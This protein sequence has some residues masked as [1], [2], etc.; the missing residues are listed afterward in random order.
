MKF[1]VD[2]THFIELSRSLLAAKNAQTE[3][4]IMISVLLRECDNLT[5][6]WDR[7]NSALT[8]LVTGGPDAVTDDQQA[9]LD[10]CMC[11]EEDKEEI[12]L[13]MQK[14]AKLVAGGK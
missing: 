12:K 10:A 11:V 13:T 7:S 3:A 1:T 14:I 9:Y 4:G 5:R 6:R 8:R 2:D